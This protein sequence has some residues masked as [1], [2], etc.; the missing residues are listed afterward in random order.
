[1]TTVEGISEPERRLPPQAEVIAGPKE[2]FLG[3]PVGVIL[4][5]GSG[6][7][8]GGLPKPLVR[9]AGVTLLERA[10]ATF[11]GAGLERIVV[12][13][14]HGSARIR[15]FVTERAST[16]SW[17]RTATSRSGT[18]PPSSSG[19]ARPPAAS[20]SPWSTTSSSPRPSPAC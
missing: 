11:R 10:V 8:L 15:E 14:G 18:A 2:P 7:R 20:S 6:S 19:R 13:V 17:P 16:S 4:A 5:A 3:V 12:V 1:M 9:V